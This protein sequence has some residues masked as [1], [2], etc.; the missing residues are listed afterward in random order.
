MNLL[1]HNGEAFLFAD[2]FSKEESDSLFL[3][4]QQEISWR[5]EPIFLFGKQIMQP[6]LTAWYGDPGKTYRYSGL[7]MHPLPWN[8]CLIK[9]K[10]HLEQFTDKKFNSALLNQY[11]S[12]NDSMGWHRDNEKELGLEPV[13]A[14]V[15][16]GAGRKFYFRNY[17]EKSQKIVIELSHG[18]LLLMKGDTQTYWEHSLPKISLLKESRINITF[19]FI[20]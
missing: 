5:Q 3:S 15:S 7:T 9:I 8:E 11:R 19:R 18:S 10:N 14:S 2:L 4:L 16:F 17:K 20:Q 6:R 13:I 12:G 1:P